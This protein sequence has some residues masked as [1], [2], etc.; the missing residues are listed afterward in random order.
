MDG[1]G[2]GRP[3]KAGNGRKSCING[4]GWLGMAGDDREWTGMAGDDRERTSQGLVGEAHRSV[5]VRDYER[6]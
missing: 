6:N 1:D 2:R 5:A 3:E 4:R